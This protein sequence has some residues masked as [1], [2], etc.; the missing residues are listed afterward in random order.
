M[1]GNAMMIAVSV[2]LSRI[3]GF[4]RDDVDSRKIR[5]MNEVTDAYNLAFLLPDLMYSLL[6][7]GAISAALIPMLASYIEKGRRGR[8]E[9]R[10]FLLMR[11]LSPCLW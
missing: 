5:R 9:S 2:V 8:L 6:V 7:G 11:H 10:Q 3:L 4:V 1:T